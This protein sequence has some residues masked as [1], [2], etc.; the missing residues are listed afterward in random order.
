MISSYPRAIALAAIVVGSFAASSALAQKSGG[1]FKVTHRDTPPSVS[2]HEEATVSVAGPMMAVF[3]NLVVFDQHKPIN[4]V[5]TIV[6]ELAESWSWSADAK[7]LTFNLRQGVKWHD[8][9]PFTAEDVKCTF[10]ML[11]EKGKQKFRKNPRETWYL[12]LKE[13]K[14]DGPHQASFHLGRPQPGI[15]SMLAAGYSPVYPCHVSPAQM[16]TKPIGTGPFK[17]VEF[18]QNEYIKLAKNTDYWKQGKP[19]LDA[20]EW[21]IV[22]SRSTRVLGFIAG[23]F[24][25]TFPVDITVPLMKDVTSQ[26]PQAICELQPTNVSTNLLI[27]RDAPPFDNP[28]IRRAMLLTMDRKAFIDILAEGKSDMGGALLPP[29]EGLWGLPN[30]RLAKLPGYSPD[31]AKSRAEA[32]KLMQE[33]GYG[34]NKR[35]AV[36]V[37]T[38][39]IEVYR[40]P[41]VILIDHLKEIY[42]DAELDIV[43]T[44]QW[45]GRVARKEYSVGL[46]LT[47][48]SVDEPDAYFFENYACESERNYTKYCN[49]ELE[50]KMVEQ[51]QELDQKKRQKMVWDIDEQLQ[52]DGARPIIMH[53]R[54]A[55]CWQPHVKNVTMHLNSIYNG[56]RWEDIWLD[57]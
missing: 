50:K 22:R 8:G 37:A 57:K 34:P 5:D 15:I 24:D 41:A 20:I 23:E 33:A 53:G 54:A 1:T 36:K 7:V 29:P 4:S 51:S 48:S 19:Y 13:V 55:T 2:I 56:W 14:V 11:T 3:N 43:D 10:D 9:K 44:S 49:A 31:V 25:M 32:R 27:N 47:G 16:R 28:K 42:I 17:F 45:F 38:R 6:P 52:L 18:K 30:E 39:N 21:T 40:D 12:N 35:L 46:N 26:R